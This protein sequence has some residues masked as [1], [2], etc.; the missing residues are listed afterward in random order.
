MKIELKKVPPADL[1]KNEPPKSGFYVQGLYL[2]NGSLVKD[3]LLLVDE[4]IRQ[5]QYELPVYHLVITK[6]MKLREEVFDTDHKYE[7]VIAIELNDPV[8]SHLRYDMEN[9]HMF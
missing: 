6:K 7:P 2:N 1:A 5:F 3:T 9:E 4:E 8:T